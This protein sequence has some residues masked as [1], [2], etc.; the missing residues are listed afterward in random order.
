MAGGLI[1]LVAY[2]AQ[3]V[4][5]TGNPQ[6]TY[7]KVV[8]RRHT[9]FS[10]ESIK[11]TVNGDTTIGTSG[12][13]NIG[14][15]VIS[16]NGDL[17][18]KIFIKCN[19][20]NVQGVCGDHLIDEVEVEIGG[21][22]IDKHFREWNQIWSELTIPE[23]KSNGFK[24]MT[25]S[26]NND[27][28]TSGDS[29]QSSIIYPL[30]F[31][32]CR[33][34]GL[35]LPLIALQY[36]EV[37][38]KIKWGIGLYN[39]SLNENLT[40]KEETLQSSIIE[41]EVWVDYIFLDTDERR[42]FTQVS[43]EYLIEQLQLQNEKNENKKTFKLNFEHPVK[44]IIWTNPSDT[45]MTTQKTRI[46]INGHDRFVAQ[47]KEYFQIYQPLNYHTS[48]PGYNIKEVELPKMLSKPI[49]VLSGTDVCK[50]NSH[51]LDTNGTFLIKS[52]TT[53]NLEIYSGSSLANILKV[54]DI[55]EIEYCIKSSTDLST[56]ATTLTVS[57]SEI[58]STFTV[59]PAAVPENS[60][61]A[62]TSSFNRVDANSI[63][64]SE[65][66]NIIIKATILG[67][68][69][70]TASGIK[71]YTIGF[72][73][74][75]GTGLTIDTPQASQ[76]GG[77]HISIIARTQNPQS[78]CSQLK[79]DINVYSFALN[80]EEHQPTGTCNFSRIDSS[81]LIMSSLTK[82]SNIYAVN[83][84][85]LRIMSGMAGLAYAS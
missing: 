83:Y 16:R 19:T 15:V 21:H 82:I 9:N 77:G 73:V 54:G 57:A 36:H 31:W 46:E 22:R 71:K 78:R 55:L 12:V 51:T 58:V 48:I 38:L 17:I 45:P 30:N 52:Q 23:S 42:R 3:D 68:G 34:P 49:H 10:M 79:K 61:T 43:H 66:K 53:D 84:N 29:G 27:T 70:E 60:E 28:V 76:N 37:E 14:S 69:S 8:Y 18:S 47:S 6:I 63:T 41:A 25:G 67:I 26:F 39:S 7:F 81:K 40:R 1:Q 56:T 64:A 24:Y 80:P 59:T 65:E 85:V 2:G 75:S 44:E 72:N 13:N 32:F 74:T 50:I 5:L 4:Y 11:Q 20:D 33:N 35:A 62:A